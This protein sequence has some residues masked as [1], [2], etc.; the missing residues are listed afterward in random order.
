M[1]SSSAAPKS[2]ICPGCQKLFTRSGYARHLA[3]S[4]NTR[5]I[6]VRRDFETFELPDH[7]DSNRE[8]HDVEQPPRFQGDFFGDDYGAQD[9]GWYDEDSDEEGGVENEDTGGDGL[10]SSDEDNGGI[11][12][13]DDVERNWEP[14]LTEPLDEAHA[15]PDPSDD[16]DVEMDGEEAQQARNEGDRA[17]QREPAHIVRFTRGQA[18]RVLYNT[19]DQY[20]NYG[21]ELQGDGENFYRPFANRIDWEFAK[22]AKTRGPGSNAVSELLKIK[23][24]CSL[25]T[26]ICFVVLTILLKLA[27]ALNLSYDTSNQL[28]RIID[29]GIPGRPRFT[30][31]EIVVAGEA[32]DVYFRDILE[33]IRALFGDPEFAPCLV[34]APERHYADEDETV[35]LFHDMHT[36]KWWWGTQVG[37]EIKIS[38]YQALIRF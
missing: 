38:P 21:E 31:R 22:W 25:L 11:N 20:T 23:G 5:C 2:T 14:P 34:F 30:R 28:N 13:H 7:E 35:R 10:S 1:A 18:G 37:R 19:R 36:G 4:P 12:I 26:G 3:T 6:Q 16:S 9:F 15:P 32:Y 33:C 17:T 24:V 27:A 8:S 29:E